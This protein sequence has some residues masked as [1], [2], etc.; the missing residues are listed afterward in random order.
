MNDIK[1]ISQHETKITGIFWH[2]EEHS[3]YQLGYDGVT[4]IKVYTEDGPYCP[5]PMLAIYKEKEI[6][7]RVSPFKVHITYE[8]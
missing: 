1:T 7:A 5:V 2:D 8:H 6:I 3:S 4:A